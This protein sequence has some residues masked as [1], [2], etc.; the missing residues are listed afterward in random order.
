[1][2]GSFKC[3]SV[4]KWYIRRLRLRLYARRSSYVYYTVKRTQFWHNSPTLQHVGPVHYIH[5]R[6]H[7]A[8][9][10]PGNTET[11]HT[12]SECP[13]QISCSPRKLHLFCLAYTIIIVSSNI[14]RWPRFHVLVFYCLKR[15]TYVT[16]TWIWQHYNTQS[17]Y[18][19]L[20]LSAKSM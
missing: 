7:R 14:L 20:P 12:I 18:I 19:T 5:E 3:V 10:L 16:D 13:H 8:I 15:C 17:L 9:S 2:T 6:R 1:M 11:A 4:Q